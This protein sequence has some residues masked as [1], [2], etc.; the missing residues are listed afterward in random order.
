MNKNDTVRL[1]ISCKTES[2][3]AALLEMIDDLIYSA[4]IY[5]KSSESATIKAI[6][7]D[8]KL[9]TYCGTTSRTLNYPAINDGDS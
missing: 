9:R 6:G 7:L 3:A 5:V 2:E 4:N 1:L 8:G